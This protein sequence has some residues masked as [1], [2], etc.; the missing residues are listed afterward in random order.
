MA[1]L[2][3]AGGIMALLVLVLV[4][5]LLV[6]VEVRA[7]GEA[8]DG[9]RGRVR[10]QWLFGLAHRDFPPR[11][12]R[13]KPQADAGP[14]PAAKPKRARRPFS[15]LAMLRAPGFRP[16]LRRLLRRLR[17]ATLLRSWSLRLRVGSDDPAET[18]MILA[19]LVPAL[20]LLLLVP[21]GDVDLAPDWSGVAFAARAE[22][23]L[24]LLPLVATA[25]AVAFLLTPA[26]WR[27]WRAARS[28]P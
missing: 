26:T 4:L 13:G 19:A 12:P 21:R 23:A 2:A 1:V 17:H 8:D 25:A 3:L 28:A 20:P 10:V 24:R 6:P 9:V 11:T 5:L 27:A 16:A 18:G 7:W 15:P 22:A 14:P